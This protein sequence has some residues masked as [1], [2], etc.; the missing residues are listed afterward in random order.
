MT[1]LKIRGG[2]LDLVEYDFTSFHPGENINTCGYEKKYFLNPSAEPIKTRVPGRIHLTVLDMN[3]FAPGHAGGGGIGFAIEVYAEVE[4]SC[5][6]GEHIIHY[7][8]PAIIRHFLEVFCKTVGYSEGFEVKATD[9]DYKHV[10]LGS[11]CTILTALAN[12][13]NRAIGNPLT[14]DQLRILIGN[15][16]VEETEGGLIAYGFETGVGPAVST[17]GGMAILGDNL[18][19]VHQ[20]SFAQGKNV[21]IVIPPSSISS[22]GEEEFSLLMNK[23]RSLDY[24]DRELKAYIILMDFIPALNNNDI[25]KMGDVMWEIEFRGSKRAEIEHHSFELYQYMHQLRKAGLEFVGMSSVGPSIAV[26]TDLSKE[27]LSKILDPLDL[28]IAVSTHVDNAG[29]IYL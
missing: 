11:T 19:V 5:I 27:A 22:A 24:R 18:T 16:Y 28:K 26:I 3:R 7:S 15:N 8:R 23:A 25:K 29:V 10:G 21:H 1:I 17:R 4:L 6:S 14:Q 13:A 20:H 12:A 9:H 2:D